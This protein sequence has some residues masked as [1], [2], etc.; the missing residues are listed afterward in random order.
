MRSLLLSSLAIFSIC[1]CSSAYAQQPTTELQALDDQLPGILIN[2]PSRMDL[3][4]YGE[5]A[6]TKPVR[7]ASIP[8]GGAALQ[9]D[10]AAV[11]ATPYAIG[12]NAPLRPGVKA[13]VDYTVG[14]YAR[15]KSVDTPDGKGRLGVRFQQNAAPYAGFGDKLLLIDREWA[16]FEVTAKAD[17]DIAAGQAVIAFQLAGA[18][19]QI[20]IGQIIV[21]EGATSIKTVTKTTDTEPEIPPQIASKGVLLNDPKK[22][23]WL[24]YGTGV[25]AEPTVTNVFGRI[26]TKLSVP[27]ATPQPYDAGA[28]LN[29]GAPISAN[30]TLLVAFLARSLSATTDD[31]N[32][33]VNFRM[34]KGA[35]PYDGFGDR[36]IKLAPNWRLYQFRIQPETDLAAEVA[37]IAIH[38]GMATQQLE[39]GPV[40]IVQEIA[41]AK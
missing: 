20:E 13:G 23:D 33:V 12:G 41:Q 19:Q 36:Q 6:K 7:D 1:V 40:Y 29:I 8:G 24:V 9:I 38:L 22:R 10:I 15:V 30:D 28:N 25:K 26:G 11:G 3:Q 34:Q 21:V 32:A 37:Q 2:D 31:G 35:P 14:F 4:I 17:R 16:Y 39:I 18:K 5:G 27:A